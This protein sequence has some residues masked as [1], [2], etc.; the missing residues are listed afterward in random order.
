MNLPKF[1]LSARS[2]WALRLAAVF[3]PPLLALVIFALSIGMV[4]IPATREALLDRKRETLQAIVSAAI[5]QLDPAL[6]Q[7]DRGNRDAALRALRG[8]RYGPDNKDY[9]WIMDRDLRMVM[10]PYR[11]DLEGQ[12]LAD[13]RDAA[14]KRVFV[15]SLAIIDRQGEG[16]V[17][18]F[19]QWQDDPHRIKPKL[20]YIR[21]FKPWGWILGTGIYVDDVQAEVRRVTGHLYA[22]AGLAG[23]GMLLLL[24]IG[25]RQG[26]R[27]EQLRREAER[28]LK[29]SR[30]RY[31]ALAHA[32]ADLALLF[33]QGRIAGANRTACAL[34]GWEEHELLGLPVDRILP[35]RGNSLALAVKAGLSAPECETLLAAKAQS[36]PVGLTCSALKVHGEVAVMLSGRD[37]RPAL[38]A[39]NGAGESDPLS[40]MGLGKLRLETDPPL[41]ILAADAVATRLLSHA[42]NAE[43]IGRSLKDT[44]PPAEFAVLSHEIVTRGQARGLLLHPAENRTI[45]IWVGN[46]VAVLCD[47]SREEAFRPTDPSPLL[48]LPMGEPGDLRGYRQHMVSHLATA[49]KTGRHA[50]LVIAAMRQSVDELLT[51]ACREAIQELGPAPAPFSLLAVGSIGRGESTL[52]TD[53]DTC[54]LYADQAGDRAWYEAFGRT[55]TD[56]CSAAGLPPCSTGHTAANPVWIL[57]LSRWREQ[58]EG[59]IRQAEPEALLDVN[60]YFDFRTIWGE[61]NLESALRRPIFDGVRDRP[62]FLRHL[63]WDTL[64]FK[65]PLDVLGRIRADHRGDESLNLK[66]AMLHFVNFARVYALR[67]QVHETATV[68]RIKVLSKAGHLPPDLTQDTLDAWEH[69]MGLRLRVQGEALERGLIPDNCVLL[70]GLPTWDRNALRQALSQIAHLQHRLTADLIN[71]A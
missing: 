59:W 45:R 17:D 9:L 20:S 6:S 54:I 64:Q 31:R 4:L 61:V 7:D 49:V 2:Q 62:V 12:S 10:H 23:V 57:S 67:H 30:E 19:W 37:L 21:E 34:L 29:E 38:Q 18:Y 56:R 5:S 25:I 40:A 43:W 55:V 27:S 44:L 51:G 35:D 52:H 66:A 71:P 39:Q 41:T 58:F 69:L 32:S 28:Q 46:G 22:M 48:G 24:A 63:A 42:E 70:S 50:G 1:T 33:I 11:P 60:I 53:Q 47:A 14:G 8:L 15:E 26:W 68:A 16:Y 13:F 65:A 36:I 3:L